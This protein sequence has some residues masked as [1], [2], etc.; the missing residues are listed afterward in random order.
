MDIKKYVNY[1]KAGKDSVKKY[2]HLIQK[3]KKRKDDFDALS[4]LKEKNKNDSEENESYFFREDIFSKTH[5]TNI[6]DKEEE[7]AKEKRKFQIKSACSSLNKKKNSNSEFMEI[8]NDIINNNFDMKYDRYKYHLLHHNENYEYLF[9]IK[10]SHPSATKYQ[11]KFEYTFKKL[12]YSIPFKKMS[13]RQNKIFFKK[14]MEK[15]KNKSNEKKLINSPKNKKL[16]SSLNI[17]NQLL[18]EFIKKNKD[19]KIKIE[20]NKNNSKLK[21]IEINLKQNKLKNSYNFPF[22]NNELSKIKKK[23]GLQNQFQQIKNFKIQKAQNIKSNEKKEKRQ[24]ISPTSTKKISNDLSISVLSLNKLNEKNNTNSSSL[25]NEENIR[26]IDN[27]KNNN[28]ILNKTTKFKG[29]NFKKMLSR[30]YL[31]KINRSREPI[32]PM[33]TPNYS[34]IEPKTIMKVIYSKSAKEDNKK[35]II[36]YNNDFTYDINNIFNKYNNHHYPKK[37]NLSKMCGR[38][39]N[40]KN[41]LPIFMLRSFDRNSID[42]VNEASLKMNNYSN[43]SFQDVYSSF[44]ERKTFNARLKLEE[45]KNEN[46]MMEYDKKYNLERLSHKKIRYLDEKKE[47]S[48]V[49][50]VPK[51]SWWKTKLGEFYKKDYD[52]LGNDFS[53]SYIGSKVDG[54]T[55]KLYQSKSKYKNLLSKREKEIFSLF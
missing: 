16:S 37:F 55:F 12:I 5:E 21:K 39:E 43:S 52:E 40:E 45:L 15:N 49:G 3:K 2:L 31:N 28:N 44:N 35:H 32:H 34:S 24:P 27:N 22:S 33:I 23:M 25:L 18:R 46:K 26:D 53:S 19:F 10:R 14:M 11:P 38:L 36:A 17:N 42:N 7:K 9:N 20:Q 47:K 29:I 13:G 30:E 4:F 41:E 50:V 6:T 8:R 54:I 51:N 1:S 48:R